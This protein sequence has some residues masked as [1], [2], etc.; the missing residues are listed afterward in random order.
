MMPF[1]K[2][3]SSATWWVCLLV[4]VL[5]L[6]T[7]EPAAWGQQNQLSEP[8]YRE[9]S[10]TQTMQQPA[11]QPMQQPPQQ[12]MQQPAQQVAAPQPVVAPNPQMPFNLTQRPGEHPLM[13]FIRLTEDTMKHIDRDVRDYTC[14]F[15]KQER[16]D[17][18]LADQQHIYLKVLQQPFSVYMLF[19]QPYAGREVAYVEGQNNNELVV[20]EGGWKR[21]MLGK[22]H[23]APQGMVA[24]R[25]Q[26]YPITKVGIRNL[27]SELN[28]IAKADAQYGE[29]DVTTRPNIKI[30]GRP[31]TLV[32]IVHPVPRQNFRFNIARVFFDNQLKVPI[33]YD[34]YLW[35]QQADE[36]PPLDVSYAYMNLKINNGLTAMDFDANNNPQIFQANAAGAV[37]QVG[38]GGPTAINR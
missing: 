1:S 4:S 11:Q 19:L 29:C 25:G 28:Q 31:T 16:I 27:M 12:P 14:T 2:L 23:L 33:Y 38:D 3:T 6:S 34:A 26:K 32:Q 8:V 22:M 13:P 18:D 30:D 10:Q 20:L 24:M 37:N 7:Y 15:I 5:V 35:P 21:H 17:G 9:T 36:Q